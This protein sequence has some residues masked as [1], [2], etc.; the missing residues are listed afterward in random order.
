M[1]SGSTSDRANYKKFQIQ[2]I[3]IPARLA[4]IGTPHP[5]SVKKGGKD[6]LDLLLLDI[7]YYMV[8]FGI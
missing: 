5:K 1:D 4:M 2:A 7:W 6:P 8:I 3:S